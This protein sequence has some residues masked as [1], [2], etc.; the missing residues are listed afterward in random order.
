MISWYTHQDTEDEAPPTAICVV[1]EYWH[2]PTGTKKHTQRLFKVKFDDNSVEV[3]LAE[4]LA[5]DHSFVLFEDNAFYSD[6]LG[7]WRSM[8]PE[9]PPNPSKKE[10]QGDQRNPLDRETR[11]RARRPVDRGAF[12][13]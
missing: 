10:S 12:V 9:P 5:D 3:L 13:I 4:D 8:H 1:D 6:V 7:A 11:A 2:P